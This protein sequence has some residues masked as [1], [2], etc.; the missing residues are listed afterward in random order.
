MGELQPPASGGDAVPP[1][2]LRA[3]YEDRDRVAEVL[4][5]AAGDG[6]LTAEELDQRLE[7]ALTARTYGELAALTR[8]LPAVRGTPAAPRELATI[9]C[10]F[11][12]TRRDGPWVVPHRLNVRVTT[13]T[14]TLDFT[15]AVITQTTLDIDAEVVS[16]TLI[17]VIRPDMTVDTDDMAVVSGVIKVK[18]SRATT[19]AAG[20]RIQMTGKVVSGAIRAR[21]LRLPRRSLRDWLR[22]RPRPARPR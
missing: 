18:H 12:V 10:R 8:D 17:M 11:S 13:G 20:L 16:G 22:R 14:V 9:D 21:P 7:V 6:R 3:S 15:D 19:A 5:I 4:R 1:G 2:E